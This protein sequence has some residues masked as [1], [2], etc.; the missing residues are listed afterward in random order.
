MA[1]RRIPSYCT[2]CRRTVRLL[3]QAHPPTCAS[4]G[5]TF[6]CPRCGKRYHRREPDP[7][8]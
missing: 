6:F 5:W 7:G 2:R 3:R 1:Q 8:A 4:F